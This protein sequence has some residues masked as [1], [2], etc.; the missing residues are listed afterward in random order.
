MGLELERIT[1]WSSY[2]NLNDIDG[3]VRAH[4]QSYNEY[5]HS[6]I[7]HFFVKIAIEAKIDSIAPASIRS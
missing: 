5:L 1:L 4:R 6:A 3:M 7:E 2:T